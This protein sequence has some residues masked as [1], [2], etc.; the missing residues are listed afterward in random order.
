MR[1]ISY[2]SSSSSGLLQR[3]A[4]VLGAVA[5][6][7][8]LLVFSSVFLAVLALVAVVGGVWLWWKTR[9]VRRMMR[10]MH[11]QMNRAREA[12]ESGAYRPGASGQGP[13]DQGAFDR[14]SGAASSQAGPFS[15][16]ERSEGVIIEGE[17][18]RVDERD[19]P[20]RR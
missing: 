12:F 15:R 14:R 4:G 19:A 13:F 2:A 11:G 8:A 18:V 3:A 1:Y 6:A 17:A 10:E 16:E 9:H 5:V 7:G 20:P